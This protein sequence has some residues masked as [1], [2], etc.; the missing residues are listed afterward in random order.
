MQWI[1]DPILEM[2]RAMVKTDILMKEM[3]AIKSTL[4]LTDRQSLSPILRDQIINKI[5]KVIHHVNK[6]KN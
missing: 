4:L 1:M 5:D 3:T 2:K 6:L